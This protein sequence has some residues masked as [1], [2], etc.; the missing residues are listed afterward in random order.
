MH[1][2]AGIR[3]D[4]GPRA[5]GLTTWAAK[6]HGQK[7]APA[8]NV[9]CP[10][11]RPKTLRDSR[12]GSAAVPTYNSSGAAAPQPSSGT[13]RQALHSARGRACLADCGRYA[14]AAA[15]DDD[16]VVIGGGPSR[17]GSRRWI[18][19]SSKTRARAAARR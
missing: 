11:G 15:K 4:G 12:D 5:A 18:R 7:C 1:H 9:A 16:A 6:S 13:S 10:R 3:V 8:R 2:K 14:S 19:L 17:C